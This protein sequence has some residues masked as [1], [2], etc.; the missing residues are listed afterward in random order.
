MASGNMV[1]NLGAIDWTDTQAY[2]WAQEFDKKASELIVSREFDALFDFRS[3]GDISRLA[4]PTYDHL[5]PIFP[6]LGASDPDDRVEFY[7][8]DIS[9]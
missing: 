8:P 9:M 6:I 5:L 2:S 7:T 1:H 3:W 4:H